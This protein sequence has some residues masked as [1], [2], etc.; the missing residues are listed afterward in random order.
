MSAE[1]YNRGDNDGEREEDDDDEGDEIRQAED[2][3]RSQ[4][5]PIPAATPVPPPPPPKPERLNYKEK[6]LLRG[7]L[8]GVSAV[9]F[10]PDGSMIASGGMFLLLLH[11]IAAFLDGVFLHRSDTNILRFI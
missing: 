9:Q 8:R 2:V 1:R 10:S 4:P 5:T 6:F 7:H 11:T 3:D